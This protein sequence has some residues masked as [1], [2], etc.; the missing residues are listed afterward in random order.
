MTAPRLR[1]AD[2]PHYVQRARLPACSIAPTWPR[3]RVPQTPNS[4]PPVA[5]PAERW[6]LQV[7]RPPVGT[8]RLTGGCTRTR[9]SCRPPRPAQV[10]PSLTSL[11]CTLRSW[12][13][14]VSTRT[15]LPSTGPATRGRAGEDD[16]VRTSGH[17]G[18]AQCSHPLRRVIVTIDVI[19]RLYAHFG[20]PF[21]AQ[22]EAACASSWWRIPRTSTVPSVPTGGRRPRAGRR[23]PPLRGLTWTI[24]ASP[25]K[26]TRSTAAT[27]N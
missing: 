23:A 4:V 20:L 15:P 12:L 17:L 27:H 22:A 11:I 1:D 26:P 21:T 25:P 2:A 10:L 16:A 9:A 18:A 8:G 5:L 6:V 19:R 24:S 13:P 7:A 3:V 14:T